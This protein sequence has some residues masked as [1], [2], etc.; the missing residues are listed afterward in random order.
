MIHRHYSDTKTT[1]DWV[2]LVL[3]FETR[4]E[5]YDDHG[6]LRSGPLEKQPGIIGVMTI[7]PGTRPTSVGRRLLRPAS[8]RTSAF[9]A[10]LACRRE[11]AMSE[12]SP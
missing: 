2:V 12:T 9:G 6:T 5:L 11:P 1:D 3:K 10:F 4:D 8:L 7:P